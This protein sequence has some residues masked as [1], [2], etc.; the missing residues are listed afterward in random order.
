MW[1]AIGAVVVIVAF[2]IYQTIKPSLQRKRAVQRALDN[3][4]AAVE[5]NPDDVGPKLALARVYTELAQR[6]ARRHAPPRR[7]RRASGT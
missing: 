2:L 3:A 1:Y 4:V 5:A 7:R 6:P